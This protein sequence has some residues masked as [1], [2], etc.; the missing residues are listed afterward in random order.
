MA[1]ATK[2][3][4]GIL[5][6]VVIIVGAWWILNNI[7]IEKPLQMCGPSGK[8][9]WVDISN[10]NKSCLTDEDCKFTCGCG[11]INKNEICHDPGATYDCVD[12]E[13][14]CENS[15]CVVGEEKVSDETANWKIYRNE[16]IGIE[17]KYSEEIFGKPYL[18]GEGG[19]GVSILFSKEK[20]NPKEY[21]GLYFNAY[22]TDYK[23]I[24]PGVGV[25]TGAEDIT[26]YCP[27]PLKVKIGG[28]GWKMCKIIKI[29]DQKAI[30]ETFFTNYEGM[31]GFNIYIYFN[32]QRDSPYK[33]LVFTL[34]DLEVRKEILKFMPDDDTGE[35][36]Q[37]KF[38]S[39]FYTQSTNIMQNQNL[40]EKDGE[41]LKAFNQMLSTFRFL[42]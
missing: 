3:L 17:F 37:E 31:A 40:S 15:I 30:F 25:F 35:W 18:I 11:A 26:S 10:C 8:Y 6:I 20:D 16:E 19:K 9:Y 2:I 39:N 33:G 13:V 34:T 4:I 29:A 38:E 24:P 28:G 42:E 21:T 36:N 41:K 7:F 27:E 23:I 22:T 12:H 1:K 14:K 5:V 32:N